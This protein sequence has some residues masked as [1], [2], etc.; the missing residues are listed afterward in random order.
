VRKHENEGGRG[1]RRAW[2]VAVGL[3]TAVHVLVALALLWP[4]AAPRLSPARA[5]EVELVSPR[6]NRDPAA[7]RD[8]A[9]RRTRAAQAFAS[10][11]AAPVPPAPP[12]TTAPAPPGAPDPPDAARAKLR[13]MLRGALGCGHA[14]LLGLSPA[15]RRRCREQQAQGLEPRPG[16][17]GYGIDPRK[18]AAFAAEAREREPF[19]IQT[20]KDNCKPRVAQKDVGMGP[21]ATHDWTTGVAC[22][23]A[24]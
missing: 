6:R 18:S 24:F 1:D 10:A 21:G 2:G 20:P 16:Q 11:G 22:A 4:R 23:K 19:L 3:S 9:R 17:P 15:E 13:E 5:V 8:T 12:T 7:G 14:D